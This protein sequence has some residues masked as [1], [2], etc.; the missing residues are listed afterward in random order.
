MFH[1]LKTANKTWD[2]D[3]LDQFKEYEASEW[4]I[5]KIHSGAISTIELINSPEAICY[6]KKLEHILAEQVFIK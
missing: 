5:Q 2:T 1:V 6:S 3:G 4:N